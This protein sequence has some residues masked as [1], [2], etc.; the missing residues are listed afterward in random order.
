[1][2]RGERPFGVGPAE[3]PEDQ[4]LAQI[5]ERQRGRTRHDVLH[6]E[7]DALCVIDH[8][9][10]HPAETRLSPALDAEPAAGR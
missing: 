10:T 8:T 3:A 7:R 2:A 4:H 6:Q 1:M 9:D 5:D